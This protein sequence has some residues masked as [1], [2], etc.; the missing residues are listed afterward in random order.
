MERG[1]HILDGVHIEAG[2]FE[3]SNTNTFGTVDFNQTFSNIPVVISSIVSYNE[4]DTVTGRTRKITPQGFEFCMQEQEANSPLHTV[5]QIHY[6]AWEPSTGT[7]QDLIFDVGTTGDIVTRN[8]H[9]I[10]FDTSLI[11][12][13]FFL[14]DMQTTG[15]KDIANVRW[16]N[17][18][19]Q[20]V[21]VQI[22]EEQSLDSETAHTSEVVGYIVFSITDQNN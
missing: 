14:A 1:N 11:G 22:D 20:S 10:Y 6:I 9:R 12:D 19:A 21:E 3:T 8:F 15:G 2:R 4:T 7:A 17:K 16:R 5:E 18:N 13:P